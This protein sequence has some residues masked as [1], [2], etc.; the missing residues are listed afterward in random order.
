M[1]LRAHGYRRRRSRGQA[2]RSNPSSVR[3][4]KWIASSLSSSQRRLR[5]LKNKLREIRIL[6]ERADAVADR[7]GVD[8]DGG[9]ALVGGVEADLLQKP[10]QHGV[11]PPGADILDG[12]V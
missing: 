6:G 5:D 3:T 1:S 2:P 7:C 11:Q 4:Q 8:L 9:A 12:G 10:L